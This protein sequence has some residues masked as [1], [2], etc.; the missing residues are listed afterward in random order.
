MS[1]KTE[2]RLKGR[3]PDV[4]NSIANLS[5][6]EVFTPPEFANQMLNQ[7]ETAWEA[8]NGSSIW[9]SPSTKFLDPFTKSG[10]FLRE[11][12]K[13]LLIGLEPQFPDLQSRIDHILTKQ[14]FGI[15][16]T[17]LTSLL[18]RRSL[19][20]S[21]DA[22]GKHSI[23]NKF[24]NS[25][26][27]VAF[28]PGQHIW[29][30]GTVPIRSLDPL[31]N[32]VVYYPDSKCTFCGV[33]RRE[34][35]R[36]EGLE[37]HAYGFIHNTDINKW[38]EETFGEKMQ[39]DV[40][41][42]NP[43]YQ[44]DDGGYGTSAGPI[45]DQFVSQAK[46]LNP[47]YLSMVIPARWFSGGKGLDGFR[48]SMLSDSQLRVIH[49]FPDSSEVFPGVQIKG[50]VCFFLWEKGNLGPVEVTTHDKGQ[51]V[52]TAT[53]PL[54]ESGADV[55]IRY[56]EAV[57][58]LKKVFAVEKAVSTHSV[59][60]A[61]DESLSFKTL[62]SS[63]KPFG[64]RTFFKGRTTK[65][66]GDV[67]VFQNGGVGYTPKGDVSK[68]EALIDAWKVFVPRAGSGSDAFPHM[69]LGKPFVGQP[70]DISTET[71]N[72]VGPFKNELE[73]KNALTYMSTRLFRFLVLMHKPTQDASQNVY[74]FVPRQDFTHSWDD[75]TLYKK[76]G[77]TADEVLF[78][79][80]LIRVMELGDE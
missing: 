14:V 1:S 21:K 43:P 12:V 13:R 36:E 49:D 58:I 55:F 10:V 20:C 76:Y 18:A 46:K 64:F 19:Y 47:R 65:Q 51:V 73:A 30:K 79:E 6:D 29:G 41:I 78:I 24:K 68:N 32:E 27:N 4:L 75:G 2:F 7:L 59:D 26:G 35:D 77:I 52:S 60:L 50:G 15:A 38:V 22:K 69:I 5:S 11:I 37:L 80:S 9:A 54:I 70:G 16:T 28:E 63:S 48:D 61:L 53:R 25:A 17:T 34:F 57:A 33:T 39:F 3:N 74:T 42:G 71:Y 45:Y 8:A 72:C 66:A 31:G 56:N 23:T 44:L 40:I 62:V 67:R